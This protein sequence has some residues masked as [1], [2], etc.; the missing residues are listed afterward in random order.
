MAQK[1]WQTSFI[2]CSVLSMIFL[3]TSATN[4]NNPV[5]NNYQAV[6]EGPPIASA[7]DFSSPA[8]RFKSWPKDKVYN[9]TLGIVVSDRSIIQDFLIPFFEEINNESPVANKP[10]VI[11]KPVYDQPD[12]PTKAA[13]PIEAVLKICER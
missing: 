6:N 3:A 8:S 7:T 13:N 10:T 9:L 11:L 5:A 4:S 2:I 1:T 12:L